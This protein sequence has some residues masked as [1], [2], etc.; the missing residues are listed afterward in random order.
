MGISINL[1]KIYHNLFEGQEN[2][3]IGPIRVLE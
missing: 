3:D 1:K 2:V